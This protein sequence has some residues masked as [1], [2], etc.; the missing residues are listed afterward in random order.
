LEFYEKHSKTKYPGR[1][2]V[3]LK[4]KETRMSMAAVGEWLCISM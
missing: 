3:Y 4:G 2:I 1:K